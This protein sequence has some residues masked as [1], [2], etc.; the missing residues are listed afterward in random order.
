MSSSG[1]LVSRAAAF[2]QARNE[3]VKPC[4]ITESDLLPY[5]AS[6]AA[7]WKWFRLAKYVDYDKNKQSHSEFQRAYCMKCLSDGIEPLRSSVVYRGSTSG[8]S[9]MTNHISK[10]HKDDEPPMLH[11]MKRSAGSSIADSGPS[12]AARVQSALPVVRQGQSQ[13]QEQLNVVFVVN[14]ILKMGLP[15]FMADNDGFRSWL[16]MLNPKFQLKHR[17]SVSLLARHGTV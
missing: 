3:P 15:V 10:N 2:K 6:N 17:T 16:A 7:V 13:S 8:T 5:K 12:K 1:F 11:K 4:N 9:I 14:V